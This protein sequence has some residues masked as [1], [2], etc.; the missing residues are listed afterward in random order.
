MNCSDNILTS[1][2]DNLVKLKHK[3]YK[4]NKLQVILSLGR[5]SLKEILEIGRVYKELEIA[6][7]M[8]PVFG[9]LY[10]L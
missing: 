8:E 9:A 7:L 2:P 3:I 1:L 4:N 10:Q 6:M 5:C